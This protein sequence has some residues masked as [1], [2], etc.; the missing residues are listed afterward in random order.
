MVI[1]LAADLRLRSIADGVESQAQLDR[2]RELRCDEA[3]GDLFA[4]P[5]LVTDL[6]D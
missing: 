4:K 2:L 6:P 3:Q 1:G 5:V